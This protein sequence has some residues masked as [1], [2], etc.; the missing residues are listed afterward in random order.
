[1]NYP[2]ITH[3]G[4]IRDIAYENNENQRLFWNKRKVN[5]KVDTYD[6]YEN[7]KIHMVIGGS[8]CQDLSIA[9]SG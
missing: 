6:N 2:H 4:D 5:E 8:P 3:V 7:V 1:M 9:K